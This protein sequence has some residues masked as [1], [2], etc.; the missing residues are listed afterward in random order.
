MSC[1]AKAQWVMGTRTFLYQCTPLTSYSSTQLVYRAAAEW[2]FGFVQLSAQI[3]NANCRRKASLGTVS[4]GIEAR[5]V[6]HILF[7]SLPRF[8]G[9]GMV[10]IKKCRFE[11][12]TFLPS[13]DRL[14]ACEQSHPR[15]RL[16]D[17]ACCWPRHGS[18]TPCSSS[19]PSSYRTD[20]L[21]PHPGNK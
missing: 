11:R 16:Q 3:F 2:F 17:R 1:G 4:T 5:I 10:S 13:T 15:W 20:H 12:F 8:M 21:C 19:G 6:P 9:C 7:E 18:C 14:R